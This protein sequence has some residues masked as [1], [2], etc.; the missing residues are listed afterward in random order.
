[1]CNHKV[2][3]HNKRTGRIQYVNCGHCKAC[4]QEKA[5]KRT[6]RIRNHEQNTGRIC[7]FI[8]L[9]Y[10][11]KFIPYVRKSEISPNAPLT[12]YRDVDIRYKRVDSDY[13]TLPMAVPGE[14]F[15]VNLRPINNRQREF[16][17]QWH[18]DGI[19]NLWL[20]YLRKYNYAS[21][22]WSVIPDKVGVPVYKDF[23]DFYKRF[24]INFFRANGYKIKRSYAVASELGETYYRPHFHVLLFC[25]MSEREA[26]ERAIRKSWPYNGHR[27]KL[28]DIQVA[29]SAASYVAQYVNCGARFPLFLKLWFKPK[30]VYSYH[31]GQDNYYFRLDSLL[32]MFKKND[33]SYPC[34]R[35]LNG[36]S[37]VQYVPVPRYVL[38][39][40]FPQIVGYNR[41][42]PNTLFDCANRPYVLQALRNQSCQ[43]ID[44]QGDSTIRLL[45]AKLRY[46]KY[47]RD[48]ER[49]DGEYSL[50]KYYFPYLYAYVWSS[51]ISYLQR[52]S[53]ENYDY[54]NFGW[55][56]YYEN[57]GDYLDSHTVRSDLPLSPPDG[58][59]VMRHPDLQPANVKRTRQLEEQ[60]DRLEKRSKLSNMALTSLGYDL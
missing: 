50:E 4:Q 47:W 34:T 53:Y 26:V 30:L 17:A 3:V 40:W 10:D 6:L 20:P 54:Q 60:F 59:V 12:V 58:V 43:R 33:W 48:R 32:D 18:E 22:K 19:D 41:L 15:V 39:R 42:P 7:L 14:M 44:V 2:L 37:I 36:Q 23:Q 5:N 21:K 46:A 38:S 52:W 55:H 31:F 45:N 27:R 13:N 24:E 25:E 51:Y 1:M 8:T 11:N 16:Y 56:N 57:I 9:T 49:Y 35:N 29:R 28:L